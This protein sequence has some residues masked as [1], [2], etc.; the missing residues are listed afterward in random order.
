MPAREV[1]S[2]H[3][4]DTSDVITTNN[5]VLQAQR[6]LDASALTLGGLFDLSALVEAV[7]LYDRLLFLESASQFD[8]STLP[9]G[10]LLLR[11]NIIQSYAPPLSVQEVQDIIY[12]LFGI[13]D[14]YDKVS[15]SPV[16]SRLSSAGV[17]PYYGDYDFFSPGRIETILAELDL[18]AQLPLFN[19]TGG[20]EQEPTSTLP[21]YCFNLVET[22]AAGNVWARRPAQAFLVRTLVYWVISD[23][24]KI[25]FYPDV[26][27]LTIVAHITN[28][29]QQALALGAFAAIAGAFYTSEDELQRSCAPW[30]AI[31]PPLSMLVLEHA[32]SKDGFGSALLEVRQQFES[33]RRALKAYQARLRS[34]TSLRELA[35][36]REEFRR[37]AAALADAFPVREKWRAAETTSYHHRAIHY[38]SRTLAP[39]AYAA[40]VRFKPP[41]WLRKWWLRRSLIHY[42]EISSKLDHLQRYADLAKQIYPD[43]MDVSGIEHYRRFAEMFDRLYL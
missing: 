28:H 36:A 39:N 27:R 11:E 9:I 41:H 3:Q 33:L 17:L 7:V 42:P 14:A 18:A 40:E 12:R 2:A 16:F 37:A 15:A 32:A 26:A 25:S 35:D 4:S 34:M 1:K 24:M 19:Q 21:H 23:R 10:D 22:W 31:I 30:E 29:L 38:T 5:L 8:F 6:A 20:D 13:P 43:G